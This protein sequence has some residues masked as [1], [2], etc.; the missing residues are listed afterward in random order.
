MISYDSYL[1]RIQKV[2]KFKNFV[3]RF[4]FLFIGV[5]SLIIAATAGLLIAK[6]AVT[7]AM[8]LPAQIEYGTDYAPTP[9]SAFLSSVSYEYS[10]EGSGVWSS[11]KPIRA[12]KYLARTVTQKVTGKGY[13]DPVGF[14]ITPL[15]VTFTIG[16]DRVVYGGIPADCAISATAFSDKLAVEELRFAYDSY[17][18]QKTGVSVIEGSVRIIDAN[19]DDITSC[20]NISFE[21]SKKEIEILPRAITLQADGITTTY[22]G[23]AVK[24]ENKVSEESLSLLANGDVLIVENAVVDGGGKEV[25]S[26][27]NRGNYKIVINTVKIMH[28]EDDVTHQYDINKLSADLVI[29]ARDITVTTGGAEKV[30]DGT[31]LKN[32]AFTESGLVEGHTITAQ[33]EYPSITDAGEIVNQNSFVISDGTDDVTE[34]YNIK[35]V[36]GTLKVLKREITVK[37]GSAEREYDGDALYNYTCEIARGSIAEGQ[38]TVVGGHAIYNVRESG[39]NTLVLSVWAGAQEVTKNYVI[40]YDYGTLT[41]LQREITVKTG[42]STREYNGAPLDDHTYSIT[43][44]ELVA[45]YA[46]ALIV[47]RYGGIINAGSTVNDIYFKI[48]AENGRGEDVTENYNITYDYGTLTITPRPIVVITGTLNAVMF[49]GNRHYYEGYDTTYA[50]DERTPGLLFGDTLTVLK[51]TE[52]RNAGTVQN[53]LQFEENRNY[54]ITRVDC[55]TLEVVPRPVTVLT[56]TDKWT[57]DGQ[58]HSNSSFDTYLSGNV[59]EFGLLEEDKDKLKLLGVSSITKAG[60]IPNECSGYELLSENYSIT[61]PVKCGTLTVERQDLTVALQDV[62][63]KYGTTFAYPYE[64]GYKSIQGLVPGESIKVFAIFSGAQAGVINPVGNYDIE[65]DLINT[66]INDKNGEDSRDNYNVKF[67]NGTLSIEYRRILVITGD[68]EKV[69]DGEALFTEQITISDETPLASGQSYKIVFTRKIYEVAESKSGNNDTAISILNEYGADVTENYDLEYVCGTLTVMPR[70]ITV[71]NAGAQKTYDGEELTCAEYTTKYYKKEGD[72]NAN[73]AG[74]IGGDYLTLVGGLVSI[75]DVA[76][77]GTLNANRY[78]VNSNYEIAGYEDGTLKILAREIIVYTDSAEKMYDNTPLT[79]DTYTTKYRYSNAEGLLNGDKLVI[80]GALA[81]I[82]D[83]GDGNGIEN[84]YNF[85]VPNSNYEIYGRGFG[86]LKIT[87]RPIVVVTDDGEKEYD[88]TPLSCITYTTYLYGDS[89]QAG[90]IEGDGVRLNPTTIARIVN[91]GSKENVCKFEVQSN[92]YEIA[93][94]EYG[95]LTVTPKAVKVVLLGVE[96]VTYGNTLGEYGEYIGNYKSAEGLVAGEQLEIAVYYAINGRRVTPKDAG[97]YDIVLD[98][99]DTSVYDKDGVYKEDGISNY[100]ITAESASAEILRR[101]FN[102]ALDDSD[103]IYGEGEDF[104]PDCTVDVAPEDMPYG[105]E[106][107]IDFRYM[108]MD[109]EE[110]DFPKFVGYYSISVSK[111]TVWLNGVYLA[112]G[113]DNYEIHSTS[114]GSIVHV[115]PKKITVELLDI[116]GV[117]YGEKDYYPVCEGN[118]K[119]ELDLPYG[120]TLT[121]F[122]QVTDY[123]E[124]YGVGSHTIFPDKTKTLVNGKQDTSNYEISYKNG[125]LE[126]V[127]RQ[128]IVTSNDATKVYDGTALSDYGYTTRHASDGNKLGLLGNDKLQHVGIVRYLTEVGTEENVIEYVPLSSN[129]NIL[130]TEYGMLEVTPRKIVIATASGEWEF[131]GQYHSLDSFNEDESYHFNK[132]TGEYEPALVLDHYFVVLSAAEIKDVGSI[133]NIISDESVIYDGDGNEVTRNYE[134]DIDNSGTLTVTPRPILVRTLSDTKV[135]DG[136]PLTCTDY[137]AHY[138]IDET[139]ARGAGLIEGDELIL[140]GEPVSV[141]NVWENEKLNTNRYESPKGEYGNA[142]YV[143]KVT[144]FGWLTITPREITVEIGDKTEAF[145]NAPYNFGEKVDNYEN[146]LDCDLAEGEKLHIEVNFTDADGNI[147]SDPRHTRFNVGAYGMLLDREN[148]VIYRDGEILARGI[149]NYNITCGGSTY[150]VTRKKVT[151]TQNDIEATYGDEIVYNGYKGGEDL[152]HYWGVKDE[153]TF[154]YGYYYQDDLGRLVLLPERVEVGEY[155]V[156]VNE[157]SVLVNGE[158]PYNYEFTFVDGTLTV[159]PRPAEIILKSLTATYGDEEITYPGGIFNYEYSLL[160]Y[161][162]TLEVF[163]SFYKDGEKVT[164]KNAGEYDI[165]IDEERP[166][167]VNGEPYNRNYEFT[168]TN[169]TLT[170]NKRDITVRLIKPDREYT[171]GEIYTYAM[172][173]GNYEIAENLVYGE[174]LEVV[175]SYYLSGEYYEVPKYAGS[176]SVLLSAIL[177]YDEEGNFIEEGDKNYSWDEVSVSLRVNSKDITVTIHDSEYIY[178]FEAPEIEYTTEGLEFDDVLTLEIKY[179]TGSLLVVSVEDAGTYYIYPGTV[180]IN[181]NR[182]AAPVNYRIHYEYGV[183]TIHARKIVIETATSSHGYDGTAYSDITLYSYY[184]DENDPDDRSTEG[185]VNGY[186]PEID[187]DSVPFVTNVKEGRIE[188]KFNIILSQNY[189]IFGEITYGEIWVTARELIVELYDD[190]SIIYGESF[191]YPSGEGNY[192]RQEGLVAGESLE[193]FA[194]IDTDMEIP[195]VGTYTAVGIESSTLINGVNDYSNYDLTIESGRLEI[196]VRRIVLASAS[197]EWEYDGEYHSAP[198]DNSD[199]SY[200]IDSD[201]RQVT[202]AIV[203]GHRFI[204]SEYPRIKDV[205]EI[206]NVCYGGVVD[207]NGKDIS[208]NYVIDTVNAKTLKITPRQI[209][210]VS[211]SD[212]REYDGEALY[213][214]NYFTRHAYNEGEDGIVAGDVFTILRY[215]SATNVWDG[216]VIN[217]YEFGIPAGEYGYENYEIVE[218]L[219][220]YGTLQVTQRHITVELGD[221]EKEY[222]GA[223]YIMGNDYTAVNLADGESLKIVLIT[224]DGEGR[225]MSASEKYNCGLYTVSLDKVNSAVYKNGSLFKRGIEN[226]EISCEDS[227]LTVTRRQVIVTINDIAAVYGNEIIFGGFETDRPLV[228]YAGSENLTFAYRLEDG[229]GQPLYGRLDAGEYFICADESSAEILGGSIENYN[230]V[231]VN[232]RVTVSR[233]QIILQT[234]G[235]EKVYDGTPLTC[236]E[237]K[238]VY[239]DGVSQGIIEGDGITLYNWAQITEVGKIGNTCEYEFSNDNYEVISTRIGTLIITPADLTIVLNDVESVEYGEKFVYPTENGGYESVEG[240]VEGEILQVAVYYTYLYGLEVDPLNAGDYLVCFDSANSTVTGTQN[241]LGNYNVICEPKMATINKVYLKIALEDSEVEYNG[242]RQEFDQSAYTVLEGEFKRGEFMNVFV[243]YYEGQTQLVGAPSDAGVYSVKLDKANCLVNGWMDANINYEIE[244]EGELYGYLIKQAKLSVTI[245]DTESVYNGEAFGYTAYN[246]FIVEGLKGSDSI[247]CNVKYYVDGEETAPVNA[248]TYEAVFDADNIVFLNG[249]ASN[250]DFD[251]ENGNYTATLVIHERSIKVTVN[252]RETEY[253]IAVKPEDE[254]Y[255]AEYG[256]SALFWETAFVGTDEENAGAVF[257][258]KETDNTPVSGVPYA[259]GKYLITVDFTNEAITR[260]YII[261]VTD[262]ILTVTGRKVRVTPVYEGGALTYNGYAVDVDELV[263]DGLLRPEHIHDIENASED[264]RYGFTPEDFEKLTFTYEFKNY[265]SGVLYTGGTGPKD[266]G[267]YILY[268]RVS[269]YDVQ[270]YQVVEDNMP[271]VF[272]I[273]PATVNVTYISSLQKQYDRQDAEIR[274]ESSGLLEADRGSL[275]VVPDYRD[276]NTGARASY[277]NAG[278]YE[279]GAYV[280]DSLGAECKNYRITYSCGKGSL[281]ITPIT[282]YIKPVSKSEYYEGHNLTL[283]SSDY[284]FVDKENGKYTNLLPGDEIRITPSTFLEPTKLSVSVTIAGASVYDTVR[285]AYTTQNYILKYAYDKTMGSDY[286]SSDFKGTL[287]FKVRTVHYKQIVPAGQSS[288]AYN[289]E[290][291]IITGNKLFEIIEGMGEGL[292]STDSIVVINASV[293]PQVGQYYN[294]L[295]LAVYNSEGKDVSKVYNLVLENADSSIITIEVLNATVKISPSLTVEMLEKGGNIFYTATLFDDRY[296]LGADYYEVQGIRTDLRHKYE[297]IAIK[298]HGKWNLVL[299]VYEVKSN[300]SLTDRADSYN[301]TFT[302][303]DTLDVI[304]SVVECHSL[305]DVLSDINLTLNISYEDLNSGRGLTVYDNRPALL[306]SHYEVSG[307]LSGH[308]VSQI[309]AITSNGKL[310]L[311]VLITNGK[312]DRSYYYN[313]VY[314]LPADYPQ[315]RVVAVLASSIMDVRQD[316]TIS[317]DANSAD[318]LAGTGLTGTYDGKL[319][320]DGSFTVSGL[321]PDHMAQVIPVMSG[322]KLTLAVLIFVPKYNNGAMS[323]RSDKSS[324]YN[325]VV[326]KAPEGAEVVLVYSVNDI[327]TDINITLSADVTAENLKN[328]VGVVKSAIDGRNVLDASMFTI[329]QAFGANVLPSNYRVEIVV[330]RKGDSFELF[331]IVYQYSSASKRGSDKSHLYGLICETSREN[332]KVTYINTADLGNAGLN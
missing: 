103:I 41:L 314:E 128:I 77:S 76:Q 246:G 175:V 79:C 144:L 2:A 161:G 315:N 57:Y 145:S 24:T 310:T 81:S 160:V 141:T 257:S 170:V 327:A 298:S 319:A 154:N 85:N 322:G 75:T 254:S 288:F 237:Y 59:N 117:E 326:E 158:Y 43:S 21:D 282:L 267:S 104:V 303:D 155:I 320:L 139:T 40:T 259:V 92:N 202:P 165:V 186:L 159:I 19:G 325:L 131:D 169:G 194:Y 311:V 6:G 294:W 156:K 218:N 82:K 283:S 16:S 113:L 268:I 317:I 226:Y 224:R 215:A 73:T 277:L 290:E 300:G 74:L 167:L 228:S 112:G 130:Y 278:Q 251:Y 280:A 53:E 209:I 3:H 270:K 56:A 195:D 234:F 116:Y 256:N 297:I 5:F 173:I 17:T 114:V 236:E 132:A 99:A 266:A 191:S 48:C 100:V 23:S 249:K 105:E 93:G 264:D 197:G 15:E 177:I 9:A 142:N 184:Y 176:Y 295:T 200:Y 214:L 47:T 324:L 223:P 240:L 323:G 232:G 220:E 45:K 265:D 293:G 152:Q 238:A 212:S 32:P 49:D 162:D 136:T 227:A 111:M 188:N 119:N 217:R 306:P 211:D 309:V 168:F 89:S 33:N 123:G 36:Y 318:I 272:E 201:G 203:D 193:I 102:Y 64:G 18:A 230:L 84:R 287:E 157:G 124:L 221:K 83:V 34:N 192:K 253:E 69:Y 304:C 210:I 281:I 66:R 63:M 182:L 13:S 292:Y 291:K 248:G 149:E 242:Y 263:S 20:Y 126:I 243:T 284:K 52:I 321:L 143:I 38:T 120:D 252:S 127:Q 135:Y 244:C 11:E 199:E 27:K 208:Y 245:N 273:L 70:K 39:D 258:Y 178:G 14:E 87:P 185:F 166:Y 204:P 329:A 1:N 10:L 95:T 25:S 183:L 207:G 58:S 108:Y 62:F 90:L 26:P 206:F 285:R 205:G 107:K 138:Y 30:Y 330:D 86:R 129:Y 279:V 98:L 312:S 255:T 110:A 55:G 101:K 115:K 313:L 148:C 179:L 137:L 71:V 229:D 94:Y 328:G 37:T 296:A 260:N 31:E 231:F 262:G 289:G 153:L 150:T 274:I 8:T 29:K 225:I 241:G 42:S 308:K 97:V 189:E 109:S 307:L 44:G 316:A 60:S 51:H 125:R 239:R 54:E 164:P 50:G 121:V 250:Y 332:I 275:S 91:A 187:S 276:I 261:E 134:I 78:T 233:R 147:I 299:V 302:K 133:P 235:T 174:Q 118:Y 196:N 269:G 305:M 67:I 146:Y 198:F 219:C 35:L 68:A 181:G 61:E 286:S 72:N 96:S 301:V 28:G 190:L 216:A 80:T 331:V 106:I 122:E 171:Y 65:P 213:N 247:D 222:D 4:R 151:I 7:T 172:G 140:V 180:Y 271:Y 46:H 22:S 163:T 12:G 88:G